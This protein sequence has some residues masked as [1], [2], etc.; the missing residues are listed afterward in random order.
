MKIL[1]LSC[2]KNEDL[3]YPFHHCIE[4]Y[5]K[6]HP[7]IIYA[8]ETLQNP[9]YKTISKNYRLEIWTKRIRETL[10]EIDDDI[11]LTIMDDDFI[12]N[13]VDIKRIEFLKDKIKDNIAAFYFEKS[14]D[15]N[16]IFRI[17]HYLGK[18]M[19]QNIMPMRFTNPLIK[20]IWSGEYIKNIQITLAERLGVEARG[21][22]YDT[23]GALRDMVQNHIFQIITLLA[24]PE[25]KDLSSDS[26]HQAKQELL[27]SLIIPTP[28]EV[29]KN[30]VRGQ[31]LGSDTTFAYKKE[32]NVDPDSTTETYVAGKTKFTSGPIA[33]VPIYFRTGKEFKEK[34]TR[35]DIVLKHI[36]NP[37]GQ[38]HSNNITIEVD[39]ESK[40]YITING[41][42]IDEPGIRREDLTYVFSKE[43]M[44]KVPDGYVFVNDSTNF[45][46]WSELK[47]YWE[48]IDAVEDAWQKENEAGNPEIAQYL[49]YRMGPKEA[50]NIFE[51]LTE[52]WIYE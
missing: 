45:T 21:G 33:G 31:Y 29:K 1:V 36:N 13:P 30:F 17:D 27:K 47:R 32:P 12:R 46:R 24:M 38:A 4:K 10:N 48:F 5:W 43:E 41:K 26:V 25:P 39:P 22:Y 28:E 9:Y 3:W 16:D 11:I 19:I 49:P 7:E 20:N 37:Y 2:D 14:F 18:E 35:I 40:I 51:S 6:N 23:S 34:K 44:A 8:T 42:K 15:E 52:H 50:D